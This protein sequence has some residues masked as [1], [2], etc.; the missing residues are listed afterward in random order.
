MKC[1]T[2]KNK[3]AAIALIGIGI[4]PCLIDHDATTL[5]LFGC[6]AVPMFF[7]KDEWIV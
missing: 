2:I 7:A 6:I 4:I 3:L 1:K 5:I